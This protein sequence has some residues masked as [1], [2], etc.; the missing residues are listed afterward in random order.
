VATQ[1]TSPCHMWWNNAKLL[2][3]WSIHEGWEII[4]VHV[5]NEQLIHVW[6]PVCND[7]VVIHLIPSSKYTSKICSILLL[8]I[9][10][11]TR[12]HNHLKALGYNQ[13]NQ[14]SPGLLS[15]RARC[16]STAGFSIHF[17]TTWLLQ[18]TVVSSAKVNHSA[19]AACDECSG[20]SHQKLV[21]A[22]PCEVICRLSKELHTSCVCSCI[23]STLDKH[24][25][26]CQTVYPQFLHSVADTGLG[27]LAQRITFC[28]EQEL[29]WRTRFLLLWPSHM[30]HSSFGPPRHYWHRCIQKTT[31]ECTLWSCFTLTT[32]STP[33]RVV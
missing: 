6:Q 5:S 14:N 28:Q 9:T 32:V 21:V 3:N 22:W 4:I 1:C 24:H 16:C 7:T 2:A 27:R 12:T 13:Y 30:E 15:R 11:H 8:P 19:P 29:I 18:L 10:T 33:G 25:S 26:T 23:T 31:Y 20:S 17:I